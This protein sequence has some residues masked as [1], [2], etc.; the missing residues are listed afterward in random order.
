MTQ[1]HYLGGYPPEL[2]AKAQSLLDAGTLQESLQRKYPD[3]HDLRSGKELTGYVQ[4]LK[5]RYMRNAA[6]LGN[7]QYDDKLHVVHNA[8]GLHTTK[9]WQ[10]GSK[11]RKRR[12]LRVAGMF[13]EMAPEFLRMIVV[14]ELAHMKHTDHN[15]EFYRLCTHMESDYHQLEFDLRLWLTAYGI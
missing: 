14:H 9:S 11:I 1:L 5:A 10:H 2:Q 3:K 13:K 15:R 4:E 8:L 6:P 7:V 12:E